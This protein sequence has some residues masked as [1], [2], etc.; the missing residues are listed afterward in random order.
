MLIFDGS[1]MLGKFDIID[2]Y[3]RKLPH[4][5]I[6]NYRDSLMLFYILIFDADNMK[7]I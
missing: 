3:Q 1:Y 6:V 2:T 4:H 5:V 7:M